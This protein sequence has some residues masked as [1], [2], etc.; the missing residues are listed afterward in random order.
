M[1]WVFGA[2]AA[3]L[4][5]IF[6]WGVFAPRSQWRALA[7][8][9]VSDEHAQEP[10]GAAYGWR[11]LLSAAG[12]VGIAAVFVVSATAAMGTPQRSVPDPTRVDLMWGSP[13]PSLVDRIL[14]PLP[15]APGGLVE[16]PILAYQAYDERVPSYLFGLRTFA[17]LG[18]IDF[19]GYLGTVPDVGVS[20]LDSTDLVVYVRGPVLCVPRAI[21]I[22]ESEEDVRVAVYYGVLDPREGP[23]PDQVAA[24]PLDA[25]LSS[26]VL[27]PIDLQTPLGDRVLI[28]L[29][30]TEIRNEPLLE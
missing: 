16:M 14:S 10:G 17:Y 22:V 18:A 4:G 3:T 12:L 5:L 30:G 27:I 20:S 23:A 19:P 26:S 25:T 28:T 29:D 2:L 13:N 1:G 8:W 7:A 11:R 24:C 21:V 9:S 15:A 6:F